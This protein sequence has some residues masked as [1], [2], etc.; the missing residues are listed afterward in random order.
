MSESEVK[1]Q[2]ARVRTLFEAIRKRD[3]NVGDLDWECMEEAD[4][5]KMAE[6][7][8]E[9]FPIS[10]ASETRLATECDCISLDFCR[11]RDAVA[12]WVCRRDKLGD[13]APQVRGVATPADRGQ[14]VEADRAPVAPFTEGS[15]LCDERPAAVSNPAAAAPSPRSSTDEQRAST[16]RVAGSTPAGEATD[17]T[18]NAAPQVPA[19][20]ESQPPSRNGEGG[21]ELGIGPA[22]AAPSS[23]VAH[24]DHPSRHFDRTCPGC[25]MEAADSEDP[26]HKWP[27]SAASAERVASPAEN[28]RIMAARLSLVMSPAEKREVE[29]AAALLSAPSSARLAA[30][31]GPIL[32]AQEVVERWVH[33]VEEC[34]MVVKAKHDELAKRAYPPPAILMT[35]VEEIRALKGTPSAAP[36]AAL[37]SDD[38]AEAERLATWLEQLGAGID[39]VGPA[40][41]NAAALLRKFARSATARTTGADM[42]SDRAYIN[43]A[44]FG[45][46]C[47]VIGERK[48]FDEAIA[49]REAEVRA[50]DREADNEHT[51][52]LK[53]G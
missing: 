31:D 33:A 16:S 5:D 41:G 37:T 29:E 51:K 22:V 46:N 15:A 45:W 27:L 40:Y 32:E 7:I 44:N 12:P 36:A 38:A 24:T 48:K 17:P 49:G 8:N 14:N 25:I 9:V 6:A 1:P 35:L 42:A 10:A 23:V 21:S 2:H 39:P 13:A 11:G 34:A 47:G 3:E 28:L 53:R 20:A 19:K 52:G 30:D 18:T 4:K 50:A 26:L 43:G